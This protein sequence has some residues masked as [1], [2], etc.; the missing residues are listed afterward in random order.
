LGGVWTT[1]RARGA[2]AFESEE[3]VFLAYFG[4][5]QPGF[6]AEPEAASIG[7]TSYDYLQSH[8]KHDFQLEERQIHKKVCVGTS[9][10]EPSCLFVLYVAPPWPADSSVTVILGAAVGNIFYREH[11]LTLILRRPYSGVMQ[12]LQ[13]SRSRI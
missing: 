11:I 1:A 3:F 8:M 5:Y 12:R 13:M 2:R 9:I 4:S 6:E 10:L 7:R